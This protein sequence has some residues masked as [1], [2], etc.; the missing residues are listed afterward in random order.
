MNP[1][2]YVQVPGTCTDSHIVQ[3]CA[4]PVLSQITTVSTTLE[5]WIVSCRYFNSFFFCINGMQCAIWELH[6]LHFPCNIS[7]LLDYIHISELFGHAGGAVR[8]EF[9]FHRCKKL[10]CFPCTE[11]LGKLIVAQTNGGQQCLITSECDLWPDAFR[12]QELTFRLR[13][14]SFLTGISPRKMLTASLCFDW[15]L[16]S[17]CLFCSTNIRYLLLSFLSRLKHS[18][19]RKKRLVDWCQLWPLT[20]NLRCGLS[21]GS[22]RWVTTGRCV[23]TS[24]LFV[25]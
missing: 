20:F 25:T 16:S 21:C 3:T 9:M 18:P 14:E 17:C 23:N 4:S 5:D 13:V 11:M 1:G 6:A 24:L 2:G 12:G 15:H 22:Q 7:S 8:C 10:K 19:G